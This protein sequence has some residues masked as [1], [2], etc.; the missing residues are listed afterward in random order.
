MDW[1][2]HAP[3]FKRL[4]LRIGQEYRHPPLYITE[5]GASFVDELGQDGKV[6]DPRRV[7]YLREHLGAVRA[8]MSEGVDVRGY[9]VWSLLDN[10]EWARGYSKRFGIVYVDYPTQRRIVKDSGEWY[11]EAI[12]RNQVE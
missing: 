4:L 5:N 6:H 1:E 11:A 8:A 2:V 9:F 3:A 12:A 10:F 7:S